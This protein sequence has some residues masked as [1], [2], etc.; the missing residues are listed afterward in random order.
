[1]MSF[2]DLCA[3][4]P[5]P[6]V[7]GDRPAIKRIFSGAGVN[8]IMVV[9][10]KGQCLPDHSAAHPITVQTLTGSVT[11]SCG[12]CCETLTPGTLV[13]VPAYERHRVDYAGSNGEPV[14]MMISMFPQEK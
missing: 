2:H 5:E 11:F 1:M 12:E 7:E 14:I 10:S 13:H 8:L 3:V 9:F 4:A 6:K